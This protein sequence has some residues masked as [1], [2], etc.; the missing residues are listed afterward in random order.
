MKRR[1]EWGSSGVEIIKADRENADLMFV[2]TPIDQLI[3]DEIEELRKI[4]SNQKMRS[5]G[6]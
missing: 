1:L 5:K 2:R 3:E 4:L 6:E